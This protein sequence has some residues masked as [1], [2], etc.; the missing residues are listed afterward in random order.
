[1][2]AKSAIFCI[3]SPFG[4]DRI[5]RWIAARLAAGELVDTRC[6]HIEYLDRPGA[7]LLERLRPW[8]RV[9]LI[10]ALRGGGEPGRVRLIEPQELDRDAGLS[11]H[12]LGVA[13][14]LAL[15]QALGELP[16][17]LYLLG[18]AVAEDT[19]ELDEAACA[20]LQECLVGLLR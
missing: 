3:G 5:G 2:Q 15:G 19:R 18:I 10:D 17:R 16:E 13:E 11:S 6:V 20:R 14:A 12:G 7:G 4:A 8:S 1:M 9:I